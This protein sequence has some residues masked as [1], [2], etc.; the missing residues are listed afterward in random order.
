MKK[1]VLMILAVVCL[2]LCGCRSKN[3]EPV[4]P[5]AKTFSAAGMNL[6]LTEDFGEKQHAAYTA[7]YE[8]EDLLVLAVK[9]EYTLF[10]NTDFS[11]QTS[12]ERYADLVWK[13]NQM[14]GDLLL[15]E[16]DD[17]LWFE[18]DRHVNGVD[19]RYRAYVFKAND[20][21][22]LV[23]FAARADRY[24]ELSSTIAG[25]G[26]SVYF[27]KPFISTLPETN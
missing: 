2:L 13:S 22:W 23:Q 5:V 3:D 27:D 9:E 26:A 4:M 12:P 8:S 24:A 1:T 15:Q 6:T 16:N 19:Y 18:Y 17:L 14:E 11:A 7:Y 20:G 10:E 25:Y 21:F